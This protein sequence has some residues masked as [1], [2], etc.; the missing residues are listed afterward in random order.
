MLDCVLIGAGGFIGTVL[1]YLI[2][3]IPVKGGSPFPWKTLL[4]NVAGA[5][6]IGIVTAL[7]AK[8][9]SLSPHLV[10]MLK[11]GVCGGFTTFS[12]FAYENA[13][14]IRNGQWTFAVLYIMLSIVPGILAVFAA[15]TL[16]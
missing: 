9:R 7:A 4:I 13:G 12:T 16:I 8:N 15:Q 14:L 6:L 11:V 3:C 2:G 5:F 1:R 10:L